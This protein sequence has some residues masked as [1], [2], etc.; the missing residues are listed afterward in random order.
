VR[1]SEAQLA[2]GDVA[3]SRSTAAAAVA[4]FEALPDGIRRDI[5]THYLH[6][7]AYYQLGQALR[8]QGDNADACARYRQSLPMF[9]DVKRLLD[10][11]DIG[12]DA[13]REALQRCP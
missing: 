9:E 6:G 12:P 8:A 7:L 4:T 13:A 11:T 2:A 3:G 10:P 1:L 5:V